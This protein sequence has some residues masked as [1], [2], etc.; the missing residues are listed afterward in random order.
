MVAVSI[1]CGEG[2]SEDN[3]SCTGNN[4][5]PSGQYCGN[6]GACTFD[7][8]SNADCN[9]GTC[10]S[11]GKCT[12]GGNIDGGINPDMGVPPDKSVVSPDKGHSK[13]DQYIPPDGP[14][15]DSAT[16]KIVVA[17]ISYPN[18]FSGNKFPTCISHLF[19]SSQLATPLPFAKVTVS[20]QGTA[21]AMAVSVSTQLSNYSTAATKTVNL[22]PGTSSTVE[23]TPGFTFTSLFGLTSDVTG[24]LVTNVTYNGKTIKTDTTQVTVA[25]RNG[26]YMSKALLENYSP[27]FVTPSDNKGAVKGL[28]SSASKLMAGKQ[29]VGYQQALFAKP[30]SVSTVSVGNYLW[31]SF[32]MDTGNKICT[33]LTSVSGGTGAD[34]DVYLFD[35]SNFALWDSGKTATYLLYKKDAQSSTYFCYTATKQGWYYLVYYNTTDNWVSRTVV[36]ARQATHYE[37]T[38]YQAEAIFNALKAM[39]LTYV[40]TPGGTTWWNGIQKIYYPSETLSSKGGNCIDGAILFASAFEALGMRPQLVYVP[41]HAFVSVYIWNKENTVIPIETT[42]VGTGT[43]SYAVTEGIKKWNQ[44]SSAKT[45]YTVDVDL[46][47]VA[48]VSPAPM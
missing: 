16:A 11:L 29:M 41:G 28:L 12:G 5:C 4:D 42:L 47:R 40:N 20:N 27:V 34:V 48:G 21:Q 39:G 7:C 6:S 46:A 2:T 25:S 45:L 36:R 26:F 38:Y 19:G 37:A 8:R 33:T 22:P 15:P 17:N 10:N 9:G 13:P 44:Y 35:S 1:G 30:L 23:L 32:F 24:N 31:E 3:H 18:M 43:F 14:K